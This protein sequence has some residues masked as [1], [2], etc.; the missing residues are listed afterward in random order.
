VITIKYN[1]T[2]KE[3]NL[4]GI[5]SKFLK[6]ITQDIADDITTNLEKERVVTTDIGG[7]YN[8]AKAIDPKYRAWKIRNGLSGNIF[9]K[10]ENLINE[11]TVKNSNLSYK[12]FIKGE[13][14]GY[15]EYVNDKRKFF[16]ISKDVLNS[17]TEKFKNLKIA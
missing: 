12:V 5:T 13:S 11:V 7:T 10:E 6:E 1:D 8:K 16:G 15:A 4:D 17:I 14:E 2:I 3:I 9:R